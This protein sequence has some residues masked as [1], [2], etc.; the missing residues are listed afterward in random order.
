MPIA[1]DHAGRLVAGRYRLEAPIG[2]GGFGR[3]YR[4]RDQRL[5]VSVAVKII[6]PWMAEPEGVQRFEQE[7]RTA[8]AISHPGVV[9]VT[10]TGVDA[11]VGPYTVAELVDGES[12]RTRM[13]RG[14]VPVTEAVEFVQQTATALAAAHARGVVH[15]DIKPGNLLL[16]SDGQVRI[17]DFGIARL[18]T[19]ETTTSATHTQVGTY[20][21][22]P[23]EQARGRATGPAADQYALAVVLYELLAGRLPFEG[24]NAMAFAL[25]HL[26]DEPPPLPPDVPANV[27]SAVQRALA[28]DPGDRFPDVES[29]AAALDAADEART[30]PLGRRSR[31][32]PEDLD[33]ATA[34]TVALPR[35]RTGRRLAVAGGG[36]IATALTVAAVVTL[37]LTGEPGN[38]A[39]AAAAAGAETTAEPTSTPADDPRPEPTVTP[40]PDPRVTVPTLTG[41]D[42]ARA[43]ER[44]ENRGLDLSVKRRHSVR[45]PAGQIVSQRP[46]RRSRLL[47]GETVQVTVSSGPPPVVI[48]DTADSNVET[49]RTRLV[50]Q[51]LTVQIREIA[52]ARD[53]G[54]VIR[55]EPPSAEEVSRGSTITLVIARAK[56]WRPVETY[57]LDSD[58][59]TPSFKISGKTWRITYTA[60]E[61]SCP[62]GGYV[63]CTGPRLSIDQTDGYGLD[64][65]T[66]SAG[67]HTTHG[68][69]GPGRFRLEVRSYH[70]E[71]SVTMKVEQYA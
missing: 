32:H 33:P 64:F 57:T 21:Y 7:A 31:T 20:M 62:Y 40:T 1:P 59:S 35:R 19:G 28:K 10:D 25:A 8:A 37:T 34:P 5:G 46:R 51:G 44:V 56:A 47:E 52:S 22:M 38:P 36:L 6:H 63:D 16:T 61:L 54:T 60:T 58:G 70:G 55:S 23:P 17:C 45:V 30:V 11:Q 43:R 67:T 27:R 53:A 42:E 69:D 12:L 68:P 2:E 65:V 13:R 50:D 41:L 3:V 39:G 66:L 49:A 48:P 24:E 29:F 4:A 18:Q 26:H 15:R 14:R 71:W 9:R